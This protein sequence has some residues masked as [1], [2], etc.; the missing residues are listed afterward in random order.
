MYAGAKS[1]SYPLFQML[2]SP[3]LEEFGQMY[4]SLSI[5]PQSAAMVLKR[6]SLIVPT[7]NITVIPLWTLGLV[8]IASTA[9]AIVQ[10]APVTAPMMRRAAGTAAL[11]PNSKICL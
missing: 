9:A 4:L 3:K 6:C 5:S 8:V 1:L 2:H 7:A 11:V 10:R